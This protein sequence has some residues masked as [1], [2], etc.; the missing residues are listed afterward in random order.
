MF[1]NRWSLCHSF[2][3]KACAK[4]WRQWNSDP[5]EMTIFCACPIRMCIVCTC[6]CAHA[7]ALCLSRWDS[8][9]V[10]RALS[11]ARRHFQLWFSLFSPWELRGLLS[12]QWAL[13]LT[14]TSQ[15]ADW[16]G[17]PMK[18][19]ILLGAV[20]AA[21]TCAYHSG[22]L[23]PF[24]ILGHCWPVQALV[25]WK[26]PGYLPGEAALTPAAVSS[27]WSWAGRHFGCQSLPAP[28]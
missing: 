14:S 11:R 19:A 1:A 15:L 17:D 12:P 5:E 23:F 8:C 20:R 13:I 16:G 18:S 22:G 7:H 21:L 6:V 27:S 4:A 2:G 24:R 3:S 25:S 10:G 9:D 28:N 26:E